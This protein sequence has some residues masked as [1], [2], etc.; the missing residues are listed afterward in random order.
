MVLKAMGQNC[1]IQKRKFGERAK[2]TSFSSLSRR[3]ITVRYVDFAKPLLILDSS[4]SAKR[5][6]RRSGP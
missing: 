3:S 5:L 4:S 2:R 6:L 1:F